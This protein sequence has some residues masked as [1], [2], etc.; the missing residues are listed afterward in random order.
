[1][2]YSYSCPSRLSDQRHGS[3]TTGG[4]QILLPVL[5]AGMLWSV[6]TAAAWEA[7][8][9]HELDIRVSHII[10]TDNL[11]FED[12]LL[13]A[14]REVKIEWLAQ[15][16]PH[17]QIGQFIA[18]AAVHS[19]LERGIPANEVIGSVAI[20]MSNVAIEHAA[21]TGKA[22][23]EVVQAMA[24]G[25]L[26]GAVTA[27]VRLDQAVGDVTE[28]AT[29]GALYGTT[30]M[31]EAMGEDVVAVRQSLTS[32]ASAGAEGAALAAGVEAGPVAQS[33]VTG[34]ATVPPR[35]RP[36]SGPPSGP[37]GPPPWVS[38]ITTATSTTT[39]TSSP[40]KH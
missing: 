31:A 24:E 3:P 21:V 29:A 2:Q 36:G 4:L 11:A 9:S 20:A 26:Y 28:A 38:A 17:R 7:E 13:R 5:V 25:L 10:E 19:A 40:V 39:T 16:R 18:A 27:A 23:S 22:A 35:P 30:T 15:E 1:M 12:A 6:T 8:A 33:V 14:T 37:P 34:A 32:G